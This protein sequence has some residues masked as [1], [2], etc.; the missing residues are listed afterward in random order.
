MRCEWLVKIWLK[1]VRDADLVWIFAGSETR[2]YTSA[3]LHKAGLA[4][5][6]F[7]LAEYNLHYPV[8]APT[9]SRLCFFILREVAWFQWFALHERKSA[10][11]RFFRMKE[12][13]C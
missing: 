6:S 1:I 9:C 4:L 11:D 5:P 3:A 13:P 12:G 8:F 10:R 7:L 2:R